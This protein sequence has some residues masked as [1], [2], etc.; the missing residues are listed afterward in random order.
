MG[1]ASFRQNVEELEQFV[2]EGNEASLLEQYMPKFVS[3]LPTKLGFN[4]LDEDV[5][6]D[7]IEALKR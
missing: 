7:V 2:K 6:D 1:R 5:S 4:L 3:K